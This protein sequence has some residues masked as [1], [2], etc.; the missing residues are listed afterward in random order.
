MIGCSNLCVV[1]ASLAAL[2]TPQTRISSFRQPPLASQQRTAT[3]HPQPCEHREPGERAAGGHCAR[4]ESPQSQAP[5]CSPR[6]LLLLRQAVGAE[7]RLDARTAL[8]LLTGPSPLGASVS[9]SLF[10]GHAHSLWYVCFPHVC[11]QLLSCVQLCD[12]WI[13]AHQ[14]PLSMGFFGQEHWSGVPFSPPGDLPDP[15]IELESPALAGVFFT[16]EPPGK[17]LSSLTR[18]KIQASCSGSMES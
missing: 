5:H 12:P 4:G 8:S 16:T 13:V 10:L 17:P 18:D 3:P 14:A 11:A 15:G 6:R 2:L 9:S 1:T 7:G